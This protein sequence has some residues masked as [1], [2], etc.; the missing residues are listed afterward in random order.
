MSFIQGPK[1]TF[2]LIFLSQIIHPTGDTRVNEHLGLMA[3]HTLFV[4]EHNRLVTELRMMNP[5]WS[6]SLLYHVARKIVG[7]QL[8][9]I[10]YNEFLPLLLGSSAIP[11][12]TGYNATVNP[13]VGNEFSAASY[14]FGHSLLSSDLLTINDKGQPT[15]VPLRD[16]FFDVTK[17]QDIGL[18]AIFRGFAAQQCQEVDTKVVDDVR[19]FLFADAPGM[20]G[21]DLVT[22][23]IQRG[24]DHGLSDYNTVR[25]SFG[26]PPVTAY[27]EIT[28]DTT[29]QRDLGRVY[30]E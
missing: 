11:A 15:P 12:Y 10:T 19:N 17:F 8:Q 20:V 25:R 2:L 18:D 9:A 27:H 14:R 28:S 1:F 30:G 16:A 6:N 21:L 13:S 23:N 26:L 7:G 22:L 5:F 4:R 3:I 29:L 24:R